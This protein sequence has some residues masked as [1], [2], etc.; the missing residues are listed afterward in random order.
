MK[1][2]TIVLAVVALVASAAPVFAQDSAS[3][4]KGFHGKEGH[5]FSGELPGDAEHEGSMS[6]PPHRHGRPD[7]DSNLSGFSWDSDHHRPSDF[8]WGS[9]HPHPSDAEWVSGEHHHHE[10]FESMSDMPEMP[11]FE[12]HSHSEGAEAF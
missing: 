9:D 10:F 4:V 5:S 1:T 2:S 11:G 6:H 3:Q 12:G 8:P 7:M